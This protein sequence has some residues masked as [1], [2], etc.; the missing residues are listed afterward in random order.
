[1][2]QQHLC[3]SQFGDKQC[4]G[5]RQTETP[6]EVFILSGIS[7]RTFLSSYFFSILLLERERL[8]R[9]WFS[10]CH[11]EEGTQC[12]KEKRD[13]GLVFWVVC[14]G[15]N[16][17]SNYFWD[18]FLTYWAEKSSFFRF[19]KPHLFSLLVLRHVLIGISRNCVV[20]FFFFAFKNPILKFMLFVLRCCF[21][22][23]NFQSQF[24]PSEVLIFGGGLIFGDLL[25]RRGRSYLRRILLGKGG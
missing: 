18:F 6:R 10:L 2:F 22:I 19:P 25:D 7:S 8:L 15:S 4:N 13:P 23:K 16:S 1:M 5:I 11:W 21:F 9:S 14:R 20:C 3:R 12:W 24:A 17:N